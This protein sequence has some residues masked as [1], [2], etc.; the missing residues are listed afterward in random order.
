MIIHPSYLYKLS[1]YSQ[2]IK[3]PKHSSGINKKNDI[4]ASS[5]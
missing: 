2:K 5:S 4:T 3:S 1:M